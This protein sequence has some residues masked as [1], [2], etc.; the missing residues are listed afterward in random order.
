M[1]SKQNKT[2]LVKLVN[3]A[4]A[5]VSEHERSRFDAVLAR[6]GIALDRGG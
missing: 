3:A 6:F 2:Y 5:I 1:K 4:N